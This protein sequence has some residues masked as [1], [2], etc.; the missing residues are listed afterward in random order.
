ML[1]VSPHLDDAAL[2]CG[3]ILDRPGVEVL[4]VFAGRPA[5]AVA[6]THDVLAGFPNSD[7]AMDAR[8]A[9]DYEALD[10]FGVETHRLDL[11]DLA[12]ASLPRPADDADRLAAAVREWIAGHG[13]QEQYVLIPA[14]T[15]HMAG[16][17][18]AGEGEPGAASSAQRTRSF[19]G[20][21]KSALG[22]L[23]GRWV[24]HQVFLWKK[25]R[26][27]VHRSFAHPDHLFVR[28]ALLAPLLSGPATHGSARVV[29]YEEL[30]YLWSR[31]GDHG[32][33]EAQAR[34]GFS[35]SEVALAVDRP[36]KAGRIGL[37][38]SQ[39]PQLDPR[40]RRLE[41]ASTLPSHE[42]FWSLTPRAAKP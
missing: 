24:A 23:G 42:R 30:P 41:K 17:P 8:L 34:F 18:V 19:A 4:T 3:S 20:A 27:L 35:A 7:A 12:Y 31:A 33:A 39:L 6:V 22:A 2:S 16:L 38:V 25:S 21:L 32:V 36:A 28:D 29:L 9:E 13:D 11:L 15:G 14:G 40:K 10:R 26:G 5:P 37:Y 1:I